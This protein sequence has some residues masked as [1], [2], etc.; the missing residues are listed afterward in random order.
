MLQKT[1]SLL[2]VAVSVLSGSILIFATSK[3]VAESYIYGLT[4]LI[5]SS[6]KG[7]IYSFVA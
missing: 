1:A 6:V 7:M 3:A 5:N 4:L 2:V